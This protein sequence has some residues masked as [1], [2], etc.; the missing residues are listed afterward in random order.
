[1]VVSSEVDEDSRTRA[2]DRAIADL[3]SIGVEVVSKASY[4]SIR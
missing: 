1:M 3:G 2:R 4:L